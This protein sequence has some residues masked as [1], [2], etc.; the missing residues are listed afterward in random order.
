[1]RAGA[2]WW[3]GNAV[4]EHENKK[5]RYYRFYAFV[6]IASLA[7]TTVESNDMA[8]NAKHDR[9]YCANALL[10]ISG[11]I[12]KEGGARPADNGSSHILAPGDGSGIA[13]NDAAAW[14]AREKASAA[15]WQSQ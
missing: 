7:I 5:W 10:D 4:F 11:I 15:G 3:I 6:K 14:P 8:S 1:V 2:D 9:V 12:Q 13:Q